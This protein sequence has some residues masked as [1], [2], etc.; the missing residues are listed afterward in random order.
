MRMPVLLLA[1]PLAACGSDSKND[2][3]AGE[4]LRD[5][6]RANV[7]SSPTAARLSSEQEEQ[8]ERCKFV[9][10]DEQGLRECLVLKNGW[11]TQDAAREIAIYEAEIARISDSIAQVVDSTF[12]AKQRTRDSVYAVRREAEESTRKARRRAAQQ[13]EDSLYRTRDLLDGPP[14]PTHP[15]S[16][17]WVGDDRTGAYYRAT[18]EA[19]KRIPLDHRVYFGAEN[20]AESAHL[21]RSR[22]PGC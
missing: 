10:H 11:T 9:Y 13:R 2:S 16:G 14:M 1:L 21:W 5:L 8:L 18:C 7:D 15:D 20:H 12:K 19:A 22:Q 4:L 17:A 3:P 6:T